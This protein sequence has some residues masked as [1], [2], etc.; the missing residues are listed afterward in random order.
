M[1]RMLQQ[2]LAGNRLIDSNVISSWRFEDN[3][4]DSVGSNSGTFNASNGYADGLI[5]RELDLF[6]NSGSYVNIPHNN[7]LSFTDGVNDLPFTFT[8]LIRRSNT[9]GTQFIIWKGLGATDREYRFFLIDG[10]VEVRLMNP[11]TSFLQKRTSNALPISSNSHL[12]VSYDGGKTLEGLKIYINGVL[13]TLSISSVTGTYT[14]MVNSGEDLTI[15]S[16]TDAPLINRFIGSLDETKFW[17][18]ELTPDE[19]LELSTSE[20]NGIRLVG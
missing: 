15:G 18:I 3:V 16:R 7:N 20:L 12:T 19:I 10:K 14:G 9:V 8:T 2:E 5:G 6:N 17:S 1:I 13:A 4:V 11:T